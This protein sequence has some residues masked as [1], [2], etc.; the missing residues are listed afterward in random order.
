MNVMLSFVTKE[1]FRAKPDYEVCFEYR[2]IV[3]WRRHL[4]PI[5]VVVEEEHPAAGHLL[6]L[7]HG[8]EVGQQAHVL[9]HVRRQHHVDHHLPQRLPLLLGQVDKD[10]TVVVL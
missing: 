7:H 1:M 5:S 2:C 6:G 9:A 8:L 4:N 10:I 3:S